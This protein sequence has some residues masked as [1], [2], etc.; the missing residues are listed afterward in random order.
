MNISRQ[1]IEILLFIEVLL[2]PLFMK[3]FTIHSLFQSGYVS[4]FQVFAHDA[5]IYTFI[6]LFTYISYVVNSKI[7]SVILR[8]A[9]LIIYLIYLLDLL[10]L[11][12]FATHLTLG[13]FFK[14]IDYVPRYIS[15]EFQFDFFIF[16]LLLSSIIIFVR[17]LF[18][19]FEIK[20]KETHLQIVL[21]IVLFFIVNLNAK[22]GSYIHS[23]IYKNVLEYN[24]EIQSQSKE[25][26]PSFI[27]E[28]SYEENYK[29][30]TTQTEQKNIII[31]MVE[32]LAS[33]QS[34]LFSGINN[35]TPNLDKI[36]RNNIYFTNFYANGFV[37]EDAEIAMLAGKFPLYGPK[38][39]SN[40]GGVSF[41]G[42]YNIDDSLPYILKGYKYHSEFI[43][44]SDLEFSNTGDWAKS[45]GFDYVEGSEHKDYNGLPRYH[46]KA[47]EDKYLYDRVLSRVDQ[48]K[49]NKFLLFIKTVSSHVPFI[50]PQ[51]NNRS[52]QETI[53]YV[54]SQIGIFYDNLKE[55]GF[56]KDGIL[57]IVGDHH[58]TMP[59][60][61]EAIKKL[62]QYKASAM[63][64]M[65]VSYGDT[66]KKKIDEPFQQT[67][68]YNSLQ[69]LVD[70]NI[71]TNNYKG[72]FSDLKEIIPSKYIFH[73]RAD[74][75][76]VVSV[77]DK[78]SGINILLN[79]D[80]TGVIDKNFDS[81]FD[82]AD[83]I[84]KI[85]SDRI[86]Q[87]NKKDNNFKVS[88]IAH[89][90]GGINN[91]TYTNSYE[92][93]D[94]NKNKGFVYFELDFSFTMDDHLVCLHDWDG[95]FLKSFG[96]PADKSYKLSQFKELIKTNSKYTKCTLEGLVNWMENN[97]DT[98]IVTD[99]KSDNL[100]ALKMILE[101]I[102]DAKQRIIPQIYDP[103]NFRQV[104]SM[105]FEQII[106]TLYRYEGT[107]KDILD[108]TDRFYGSF[109]V[110]MPI[111]KAKGGL[112]KILTKKNIP[113]Y[114]HTVNK[115]KN[116][117]IL[118]DKFG[119]SEIY[120]DFIKPL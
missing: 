76:G 23:W 90:G 67:D 86:K 68:I 40:A 19:N 87:S 95:D 63:V 81:D 21:P 22:D 62:G 53:Q 18:T 94:H 71:V 111:H 54:D 28:F 110:T 46:F 32:S 33:Y 8:L 93:L 14:F 112:A 35:W 120:T 99:A 44:S 17:F 13:D 5:I 56:F 57:I 9:A 98:F 20:R 115:D 51:N 118:V 55:K 64:P 30:K 97:P 85:N 26:S 65:I 77:F 96:V 119:V 41:K 16:L 25:Y 48:N 49:E 92:A 36:A 2:V 6:L 106:W 103:K 73:K 59:V 31:L 37:T 45:I 102:P 39:F 42:F 11:N 113:T 100:K 15:Q 80:D 4:I 108:W 38:I 66:V 34:D 83:I 7:L 72:N 10:I 84:A 50:N 60:K 47:A 79:G 117:N 70:A 75:R 12:F 69:S 29:Y 27:K 109:A 104:K 89:A 52:E 107:H 78:D 116:Y 91:D 74:R 82:T 101:T 24:M 114:T 1:K 3:L 58:P 88:R 61:E 43:T 105:G